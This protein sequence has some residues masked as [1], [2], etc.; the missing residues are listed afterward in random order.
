[1]KTVITNKLQQIQHIL[2][3]K[4][5]QGKRTIKLEAA[6]FS[7]GRDSTNSVVLYSKL[8]SRQHAI[9]LRIPIP[10]TASYL[11]R[12]IDGNLQGNR[13][14]NGITVNGKCCFSHDLKHGDLI[15]FGGDVEAIYY[16]SS[17]I[18][19][20]DLLISSEADM[21]SGFPSD[22]SDPTLTFVPLNTEFENSTESALVRLASFPELLS[23]PIIEITLNGKI[24]YLNPAAL[25][26]FPGLREAQL[27]HPILAGLLS[28]VQSSKDKEKFF[29]REV[30][31]NSQVFE[32]SIHYIAE[33]DLIRSY[34]INITERKQIEAAL[35]QA[36]D[37]LEIRVAQRTAE[38]SKVN[39]QLRNEIIE[40]QRVEQALRESEEQL[41]AILDN[42]TALI[43]I[44]NAQG[45]Y[46]LVN[47]WYE[48]LFHVSAEEIKGKT[49]YDLFP[50]EI[51]DKHRANDFIVLAAL[52]ALEWEEVFPQDDGAHTYLSIKFPLYNAAG[53][54]YAVCGI[55][56]DITKRKHAE[57]GIRKALEKEKELG[58]LKSRFIT[59]T[60]HEFRTPL[61]TI[62]SSTDLLKR[63]S[64]KFG[65]DKKLDYFQQIQVAVNH[66]TSLLSNV[67]LIG[68]AEA[69]NLEFQPTTLNLIQFCHDLVEEIQLTASNHI[70]T[71]CTQEQSINACL[72]EKLLRQILN[73]L[74][75]NA[76]KYSPQGSTVHFELVC[77]QGEAIF[78]IQDHGIGIPIA[79]QAQLFNSFH[80]ASNVGTISG[81][82]LGL[83]IVK[84]SVDLHGGNIKVS[85]EVGVG[86]T[87]TVTLPVTSLSAA[88][89]R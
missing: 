79:D 59:T 14:T 81:T 32:Q 67:L 40:R 37:E 18:S 62:L 60:S 83:A 46:I 12:L 13:S 77:Q 80:R 8:V 65:E 56:T 72:D 2:L 38:L 75:S 69:G 88:P 48:T 85:S 84:K 50:Q 66:M 41:Q 21:L 57:E 25:A 35:R 39:K 86:T 1:M 82:G 30:E 16:A 6:T 61:A 70:I 23:N 42:S 58:E 29:V 87:F 28:K 3:I 7:I 4:D 64:H 33:S 71:F 51:A 45:E 78:R 36:H 31:Y 9:L 26:Q 49:D 63:Y 44:K 53:V 17:S 22:L 34:L 89:K 19:D 52:A 27:Q 11:F 47:H 74:L 55:S 43:Y 15:G 24:T 20:L 54:A 5:N 73:N 68:D 76:I 10:E